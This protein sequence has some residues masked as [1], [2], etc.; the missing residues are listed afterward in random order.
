[1]PPL[2]VQTIQ[3]F[4]YQENASTA[5]ELEYG[6]TTIKGDVV[7]SLQILEEFSTQYQ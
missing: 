1:M 3:V 5:Q 2:F 6:W 4:L 7:H